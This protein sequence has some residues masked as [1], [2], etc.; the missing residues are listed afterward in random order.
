MPFFVTGFVGDETDGNVLH[1]A[2][3]RLRVVG[4]GNL[5]MQLIGLDNTYTQDIA[6]LAIV[7]PNIKEPTRIANFL[8]QRARLKVQTDEINEWF[9]INTLIFFVKPI[10]K[11][12]PE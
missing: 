1:F 5:D 6:P 9:K 12:I 11:T 2:S 10:Y 4:S 8:S 3:V 7:D